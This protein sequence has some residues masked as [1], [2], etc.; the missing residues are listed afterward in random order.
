MQFFDEGGHDG[1]SG[2]NLQ[3]SD[4]TALFIFVTFGMHIADEEALHANYQFMGSSGLKPCLLCQNVVN[5]KNKRGIIETD[6]SW[7]ALHSYTRP[8]R[9][10]PHTRDT[11]VSICNR[12]ALSRPTLSATDFQ[13]L[14]QSLV[15]TIPHTRSWLTLY[16]VS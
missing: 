11:V 6:T 13:E 2:I 14:Q 4:G 1:R 12:L 3:L 15:G 9:I 7:V 16:L 10:V 8:A 5:G